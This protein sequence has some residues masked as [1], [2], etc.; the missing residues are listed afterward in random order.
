MFFIFLCLGA[1]SCRDTASTGFLCNFSGSN[2]EFVME[3]ID[4]ALYAQQINGGRIRILSYD[5]ATMR[6]EIDVNDGQCLWIANGTN[7]LSPNN[8]FIDYLEIRRNSASEF[9]LSKEEIFAQFREVQNDVY[10][11]QVRE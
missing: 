3:P 10:E 5:A 6:A 8:L 9:F 11:I 4:T 1:I 7:G 2:I